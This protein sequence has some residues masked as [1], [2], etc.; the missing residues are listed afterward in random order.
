MIGSE[1]ECC[2]DNPEGFTY[3]DE[4]GCVPCI[5]ELAVYNSQVNLQCNETFLFQCQCLGGSTIH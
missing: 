3:S 1:R 5:G 4:N 2:V